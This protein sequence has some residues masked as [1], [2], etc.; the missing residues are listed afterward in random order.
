MKPKTNLR[1]RWAG[2]ISARAMPREARLWPQSW[3]TTRGCPGSLKL[4]SMVR[5]NGLFHL[6]TNGVYW[7]W[8]L[9]TNH[10]ITKELNNLFIIGV[11]SE[12]RM[13]GIQQE[14][15]MCRDPIIYRTSE[16]D[17]SGCM[18]FIT[19]TKHKEFRFHETILS[20]GGPGSLGHEATKK[21]VRIPWTMTFWLVE[22]PTNHDIL[23]W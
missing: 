3:L 17:G 1:W 6:L 7:G 21:I 16:D 22:N 13:R 12:P 23:V 18:Y 15:S 19:E 11:F 20:F 5:I 2:A 10:L 9:L 4:G 8:N 14:I